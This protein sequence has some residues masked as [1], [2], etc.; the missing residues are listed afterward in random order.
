LEQRG[1]P[2]RFERHGSPL[3]PERQGVSQRADAKYIASTDPD[4]LFCCS[5]CARPIQSG[6]L[7]ESYRAAD[8]IPVA[9][10]PDIRPA[11]R[12]WDHTL[13]DRAGTDIRVSG[14]QTVGGRIAL[15]YLADATQV[16]AADAWDYIYPS[17][18]R[19]D[20]AKERLYIKAAGTP[21]AFGGFQTWLFEYDLEQRRQT[22]RV[23]VD[24]SLLP[25]EC[26]S[27]F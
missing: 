10:A 12:A 21:V 9:I 16:I 11:T 17:D 22:T 27:T 24:P 18:V 4:S 2:K 7:L 13:S 23:Q 1:R 15:K 26:P 20:H 19:V 8:C 14:V 25:P 3:A 6:A 5:E